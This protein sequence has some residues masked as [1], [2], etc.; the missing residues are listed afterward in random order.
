MIFLSHLPLRPASR[1]VQAELRD[2][3]Q[4]HRTLCKAFG[5][6]PAEYEAARCLFRVDGSDEGRELHVLVQSLRPPD[7]SRLTVGPDYLSAPPEA[8]TFAPAL[9]AGQR[10]RFRLRA[11]PTLR[12]SAGTGNK[13]T[14]IGVYGEEEQQAWLGRKGEAGGFGVPDCRVVDGGFVLCRRSGGASAQRHLCATFDG[15]L[16]VTD[17]DRLLA[18][19]AS[20]LGS[21]K[22][23]GFGLLSL[24]RA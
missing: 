14:R 22:A 6:G 21:G 24:A 8:K 17:P 9:L 16:Q 10:L 18:T 4:M 12:R 7:W 11:N 1:Q 2:P 20:G 23:F 15:L 5:D 13:G 19:L 3:Y